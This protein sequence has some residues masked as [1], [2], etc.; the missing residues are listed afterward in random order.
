[1]NFPCRGAVFKLKHE[2]KN[3]GMW[4]AIHNNQRK[5][6]KQVAIALKQQNEALKQKKKRKKN[7][8]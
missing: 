3:K 7:I 6:K 5:E 8:K 4:E 1:M 2:G